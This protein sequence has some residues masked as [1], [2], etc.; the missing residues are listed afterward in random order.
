MK[1]FPP[2]ISNKDCLDIIEKMLII[3]TLVVAIWKGYNFADE[4]INEQIAAKEEIKKRTAAIGTLINTYTAEL[5]R[6]GNDIRKLD[7][8]I[9]KEPWVT[10]TGAETKLMLRQQKVKDKQELI[11]G[12]GNQII[13]WQAL[14]NRPGVGASTV[15]LIDPSKEVERMLKKGN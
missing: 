15:K 4:K 1:N 13:E 6:I 2:L 8:A 5:T 12:L 7:D 9:Q 14:E 10:S 11:Q 3:V